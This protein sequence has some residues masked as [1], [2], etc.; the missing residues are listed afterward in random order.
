MPNGIWRSGARLAGL[1]GPDDERFV[2]ADV[3]ELDCAPHLRAPIHSWWP[4]LGSSQWFVIQ[5]HLPEGASC[6]KPVRALAAA[7]PQRH[8]IFDPFIRGPQ[9]AWQGH[10]RL[11]VL[12]NVWITTLGLLDSELWPAP[13]L[14]SALH[15]VCGEVGASKLLF[16][17]GYEWERIHELRPLEWLSRIRCLDDAQ[18]EL[19]LWTNAEELFRQLA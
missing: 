1:F 18:R 19:I 2:P 6:L 12:P 16:A 7:F 8:F 17:S 15:F 9:S 5:M 14:E 4:L 11:A 3:I 10:T 13:E